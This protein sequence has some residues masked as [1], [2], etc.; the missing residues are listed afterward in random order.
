MDMS[1]DRQFSGR[2][3]IFGGSGFLGRSLVNRL[4]RQGGQVVIVSRLPGQAIR[5][6]IAGEPGQVLA[7]AADIHSDASVA[8]AVRGADCV[9]NLIG[10][11]AQGRGQASFDAIHRSA[12]GR[13]AAAAAAA[14]ARQLV[15]VSALGADPASP[16]AY[17]RSKAQGEAAVRAAFPSASIIRP[18]IIFGPDDGFFNLFARMAL[19]SPFLPLIGGGRTRFQ[20]VYSGDVVEAVLRLLDAPARPA[21]SLH[22]LGGP[23]TYSFAA[24]IDI[25]LTIIGRPNK[26]RLPIG[27]GLASLQAFFLERLPG[28]LLTRD[29]VT[30]LRKDNIV[31]GDWPGLADLG[32]A[33]T[34]LELVVPSYLGRYR[35]TQERNKKNS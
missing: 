22:E 6:A 10:V 33:P 1:H 24:L 27:F 9:I 5:Q 17:A 15:H 26:L 19:V 14:G 29:Q 7:I 28:A 16:S 23:R 8:M 11:L 13:I 31:S 18:S 30:L 34:C 35:H 32:I 21:G 12:A 25:I 3:V 2:I 4:A 20:P